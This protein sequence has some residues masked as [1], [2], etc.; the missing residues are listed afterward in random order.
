MDL[1]KHH[2]FSLTERLE[3][4]QWGVGQAEG[5]QPTGTR[6]AQ[7]SYSLIQLFIITPFSLD[8]LYLSKCS[9]LFFPNM[10]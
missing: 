3:S 10:P 8:T 7:F 9:Y 6:E 1:D 4:Q 2:N 5:K